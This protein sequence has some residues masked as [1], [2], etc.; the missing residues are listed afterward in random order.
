MEYWLYWLQSL[1]HFKGET[2]LLSL[3]GAARKYVN[4]SRLE[5]LTRYQ[6]R[7]TGY[8]NSNPI[9]RPTPLN[10]LFYMYMY[11]CIRDEISIDYSLTFEEESARERESEREKRKPYRECMEQSSV[12]YTKHSLAHTA[13]S[14]RAH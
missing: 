12:T 7:Y 10:I 1:C 2:E 13:R 14:G 6:R 3:K 8:Y 11:V 5:H 9:S 4:I